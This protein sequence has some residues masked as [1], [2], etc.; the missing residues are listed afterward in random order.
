MKK[1]TDVIFT[2]LMFKIKKDIENFTEVG[3]KKTKRCREIL[4]DQ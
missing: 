3:W 1:I 4:K 2:K